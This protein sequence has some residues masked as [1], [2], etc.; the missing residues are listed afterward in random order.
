MR[1]IIGIGTGPGASDLLTVRAVQ[2]IE[3][4]DVIFAPNNRGKNMAL[5]TVRPYLQDQKIVM[6]D[7]PMGQSTD[8]TY[9][10]ARDTIYESLA[11]DDTGVFLNIGDSSIYSTFLNMMNGEE[12]HKFDI[13]IIP[14]I[15]SFIAAAN[16]MQMNLVK[17][18]ETLM[19]LDE[20]AEDT[21]LTAD[22]FAI[23]KTS[24]LESTLDILDAQGYD[25]GYIEYASLEN[26]LVLTDREEM[27]K[28]KNYISLLIAR[29]KQG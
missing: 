5:D 11:E 7:F 1:K 21:E 20:V 12:N 28:R 3:N 9:Q 22:A 4:E 14:G 10:K 2:T 27:L 26:E 25:Y 24:K 29:K 15:P 16:I 13:E 8:E 6:L 17:K 19:L 23:L 18:G